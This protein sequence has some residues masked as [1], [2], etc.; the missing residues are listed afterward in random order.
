MRRF[1]FLL[2][3]PILALLFSCEGDN[4]ISPW[5][6]ITSPDNYEDTIKV[7]QR[8]HI[9]L[10]AHLEDQSGL[11]SYMIRVND[12][13]EDPKPISGATYDFI[14]DT[15]FKNAGLYRL[16]LYATNMKGLVSE[17]DIPIKADS[18][19]RPSVSITDTAG[20]S[21]I[22][23][24]AVYPGQSLQFGIIAKK[25]QLPMDSVLITNSTDKTFS[26]KYYLRSEPYN[27]DSISIVFSS[28]PIYA[29]SIFTFTVKDSV[30]LTTT[31]QI[32]IFIKK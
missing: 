13:I 20:V 19:I 18:V 7:Y 29:E 21:F 31:K 32:K 12:S 15:A 25:G 10:K 30:D 17:F 9:N 11:A 14:C 2:I 22:K 23:D 28:K 26:D 3:I 27:T 6:T 24:S 8:F 1:Y 4:T 5:I 16:T